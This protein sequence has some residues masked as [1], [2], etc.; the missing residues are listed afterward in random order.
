MLKG[1][2]GHTVNY[3]HSSSRH[4]QLI[5]HSS[6]GAALPTSGSQWWLLQPITTVQTHHPISLE[7]SYFHQVIVRVKDDPSRQGVQL[8]TLQNQSRLF[9]NKHINAIENI[10]ITILNVTKNKHKYLLTLP[11]ASPS[12]RSPSTVEPQTISYGLPIYEVASSI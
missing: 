12:Q 2:L 10:K 4:P 9:T 8:S 7:M 5:C 1:K 11:Q 3:I 6:Q